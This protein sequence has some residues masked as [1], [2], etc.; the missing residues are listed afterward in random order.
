MPVVRPECVTWIIKLFEAFVVR[1]VSYGQISDR[2][3]QDTRNKQEH[4]DSESQA[5]PGITAETIRHQADSTASR[6]HA[7]D[8]FQTTAMIPFQRACRRTSDR[9]PD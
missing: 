8:A 7:T 1:G 4:L 3:V 6:D 5:T 9:M 2:N